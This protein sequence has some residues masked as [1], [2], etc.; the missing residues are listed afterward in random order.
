MLYRAVSNYYV[1]SI[2]VYTEVCISKP[3]AAY[4]FLVKYYKSTT[5]RAYAGLRVSLVYSNV[6][7]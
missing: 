3:L 1:K 6:Q 7:L 2:M 4:T 5:I